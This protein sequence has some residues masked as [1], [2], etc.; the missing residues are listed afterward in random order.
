MNPILRWPLHPEPVEGEALS[1]WLDRVAHRYRLD[2]RELLAH[3]TG[4]NTVDKLDTMPSASLLDA[5][6]D[7][8]GLTLAQLRGMHLSGWIPWLL[9]SMDDNIPSAQKTYVSQLSVLMSASYRKVKPHT[10]WQA[11]IPSEA[12]HRAC[13]QCLG[14]RPSEGALLLTWKLPLMLSCPIH[15]CWLE[16]YREKFGLFHRWVKIPGNLRQASFAV[17]VMDRLTWQAL[18][19]GHVD[20]PRRRVHAGLWFR[21]LRTLLDELSMPLVRSRSYTKNL[22]CIWEKSHYP[23]CT[24]SH[25]EMLPLQDQLGMLEAAA[26]AVVLLGEGALQ[27]EGKFAELFLAE[28]QGDFTNG[29]TACENLRREFHLDVRQS[30]ARARQEPKVARALFHILMYGKTTFTD[31]EEIYALFVK[32]DIPLEFLSPATPASGHNMENTDSKQLLTCS[33]L[34]P[35]TLML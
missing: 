30:I 12:I 29:L 21:L 31:R 28:P 20:L 34:L 4:N 6:S 17:S 9:D 3:C 25:F 1:S 33:S 5:L 32:E 19:V 15:G 22:L 23:L 13:P 14:D 35:Q 7:K 2:R 27:P 8:S 26:N 10:Q 18:T 24:N 11:W 16:S